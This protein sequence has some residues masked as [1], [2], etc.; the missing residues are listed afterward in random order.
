MRQMAAA[1]DV[2]MMTVSKAFARLEERGVLERV[3]GRGMRI[4]RLR[5]AAACARG[6]VSCKL[7]PSRSS[8]VAGSLA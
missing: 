8:C 3:R 7:L 1:L 6:N 2:N 5:L 4:V